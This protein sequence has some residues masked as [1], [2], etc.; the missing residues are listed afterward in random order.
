MKVGC[1]KP[2]TKESEAGC[3]SLGGRMGGTGLHPGTRTALRTAL[4]VHT[5][6]PAALLP[7][8]IT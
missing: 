4:I 7:I 8:S 6:L 2:S 5:L 3:P 1:D